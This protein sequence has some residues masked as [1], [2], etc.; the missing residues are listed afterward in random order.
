MS[1]EL[2]VL[3]DRSLTS[4]AEWQLAIDSSGFPLRL[5]AAVRLVQIAHEGKD[6]S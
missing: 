4:I 1:M 6:A 2:Y 3:S 5:S